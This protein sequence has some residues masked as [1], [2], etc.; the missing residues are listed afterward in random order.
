ME[1]GPIG[2][3]NAVPKLYKFT[4]DKTTCYTCIH[5]CVYYYSSIV[6]SSQSY[7]SKS[8][9]FGEVHLTCWKACFLH[10]SYFKCFL[11]SRSGRQ[12]WEVLPPRMLWSLKDK[13]V[14]C[15]RQGSPFSP[16]TVTSFQHLS[17][18]LAS[19][20]SLTSFCYSPST[21]IVSVFRITF[22]CQGPQ[23]DCALSNCSENVPLTTH[24]IT[25]T[26]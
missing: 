23:I 6:E 14:S 20:S 11:Y 26:H 22:F 13:G 5:V 4:P 9:K 8:F 1:F 3:Q 16:R 25:G 12:L 18:T 17:A 24:L 7:R 19:S 2:K 10:L 21:L 15:C